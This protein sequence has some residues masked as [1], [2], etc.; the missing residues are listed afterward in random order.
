MFKK[1][2]FITNSIIIAII[3]QTAV[4]AENNFPAL[5]DRVVDEAGVLDSRGYQQLRRML[6]EY[7]DK[8]GTQ[9]VVAVLKNLRGNEISDYA[10]ELARKWQIGQ[11]DKNTGLLILVA[12]EERKV[13]IEVGYGLEGLM[14]DA[15]SKYIIENI[16]KPEFKAGKYQQ[17]LLRGVLTVIEILSGGE[18]TGEIDKT[19]SESV[20]HKKKNKSSMWINLLFWF[21]II[22]FMVSRSF[23]GRSGYRGGGFYGGGGFGGFSGGG[24]GFSGGGGSFGGG[25]ASGDW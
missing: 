9:I 15:R 20:S 5:T 7:E 14:T 10:V 25:G 21:I 2:L 11:K 19:A 3:L 8:T 6:Q 4:Y 16:I 17:G 1:L 13:R 23:S 12:F 24:G 18:Q 22:L